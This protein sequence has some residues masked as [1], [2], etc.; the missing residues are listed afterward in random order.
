MNF[1]KYKP[2][3]R[4]HIGKPVINVFRLRFLLNES[5]LKK[6]QIPIAQ[7]TLSNILQGKLLQ[8]HMETIYLLAKVLETNMDDLVIICDKDYILEVDSLIIKEMLNKP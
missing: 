6:M 5:G 8:G 4:G 1:P 7:P 2:F 3:L